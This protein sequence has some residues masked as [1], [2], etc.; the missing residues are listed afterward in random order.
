MRRRVYGGR[1]GPRVLE[2][3]LGDA[4]SRAASARPPLTAAEA[5]AWAKAEMLRRGRRFVTVVAARRA[6]RRTWSSAAGCTLQL[7]GAP[8][9]GDGYYV[10]RVRHTYDLVHG[11]RTALRGRTGHDQR[12]GVMLPH[13]PTAPR[14][15]YFG[16]YPAIVT[17]IVDP[18]RLG[19]VEVRFPWLGTDGDRDVRAWA[20]LC[21]PYADDDQGLADP[22]RG[23]TARSS[24]RSRP[25]TCAARTSS[26]PPGT[27]RTGLPTHAAAPTT[28]GCC[29]PAADSRLEFDD[30]AG[31]AK[32][33]VSTESGTRSCSTTA[34]RR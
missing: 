8:F 1:T 2:R 4:A 14:A 11:L 10:T 20:T 23:R 27:A 22:A 3:A 31:A 5:S 26:A 17:D 19:R 25:A 34:P 24:W 6:A 29:A 28:C 21:S 13:R 30:T 9:E 33:T 16:V 7:V 12:G 32:V 18:D 15:A